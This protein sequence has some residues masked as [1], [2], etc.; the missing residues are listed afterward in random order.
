MKSKIVYVILKIIST[1]WI[2]FEA[3]RPEMERKIM[4]VMTQRR[5][6]DEGDNR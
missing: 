3:R 2:V 5:Q 1:V 4:K 6:S